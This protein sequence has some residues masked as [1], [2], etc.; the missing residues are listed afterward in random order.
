MVPAGQP[1]P[2]PLHTEQQINEAIGTAVL[3][4]MG[5]PLPPGTPLLNPELAGAVGAATLTNLRQMK[6]LQLRGMA[7]AVGAA[8]LDTLKDQRYRDQELRKIGASDG[9]VG[10]DD[11]VAGAASLRQQLEQLLSQKE[12]IAELKQ[13]RPP[14]APGPPAATVGNRA[15]PPSTEFSFH[16]PADSAS[17]MKQQQ[18]MH[19]KVA[20]PVPAASG[21][22][23]L[24]S[25]IPSPMPS[26]AT[27]A[28]ASESQTQIDGHVGDG[29]HPHQQGPVAE[30][31]DVSHERESSAITSATPAAPLP[32]GP[33]AAPLPAGPP[34]MS[35]LRLVLPDPLSQQVPSQQLPTDIPPRLAPSRPPALPG[36]KRA[37]S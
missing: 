19:D 30:G 8:A 28:Q 4:S 32:P 33:P 16:L 5:P 23:P 25:A 24:S 10:G 27:T 17:A 20:F 13:Q 12:A 31:R 3:H 1:L 14:I 18:Y 29:V 11:V 35:A 7:S 2:P 34:P 26:P 36:F 37:T 22:A 6:R 15:A 21:T 9:G